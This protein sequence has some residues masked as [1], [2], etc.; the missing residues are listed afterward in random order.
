[1]D[2]DAPLES[3]IDVSNVNVAS[4]PEPEKSLLNKLSSNSWVVFGPTLVGKC[5]S[6]SSKSP[7]DL[8]RSGEVSPATHNSKE[9]AAE[10]GIVP[11]GPEQD[12]DSKRSS[13]VLH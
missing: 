1:M 9:L 3:A 12:A 4:H 5:I 6:Y 2:P 8:N 11:V 13:Y 10:D 7:G